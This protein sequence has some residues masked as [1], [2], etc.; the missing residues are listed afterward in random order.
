LRRIIQRRKKRLLAKA[1]KQ[2]ETTYNKISNYKL[3][4]IQ[5]RYGFVY[6]PNLT[7]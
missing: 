2:S 7:L 3:T 4:K 6:N 1:I 5:R